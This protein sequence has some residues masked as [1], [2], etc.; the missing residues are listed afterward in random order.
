MMWKT[1]TPH[2]NTFVKQQVEEKALRYVSRDNWK[3]VWSF[4]RDVKE[5]GSN[6]AQLNDGL[7]L[8]SAISTPLSL[9]ISI[10]I[11]NDVYMYLRFMAVSD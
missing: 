2:F 11:C 3:C 1:L 4:V 6:W 10:Y 7:S 9:Y 8:C 5:D